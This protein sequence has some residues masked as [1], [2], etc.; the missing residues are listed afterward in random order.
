[1]LVKVFLLTLIAVAF[2]AIAIGMKLIF[3]KRVN[4]LP[5]SCKEAYP[6]GN[7]FSCGCSEGICTEKPDAL[8]R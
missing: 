4:Q 5:R 6:E 8:Q 7:G 3:N 2:L 1:M